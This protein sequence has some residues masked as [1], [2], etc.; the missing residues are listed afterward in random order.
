[1]SNPHDYTVG[2]ICA[3]LTEYVAAQAFLDEKHEGPESVSTNDN[4]DYTLGRIGKHNV[5]IAVLPHGE[6][7]ISSAA[8]VARDMLHSFPNVKIGLMVGIGGGAPSPKHDIR[9]GDIV[10]SA[11]GNGKGGV[12]QFDYGKV[13]QNE[14]FQETGFLNQPPTILRAAVHGLM[15]QYESEGHQLEGSINSILEKKP[16]LRKKYKRPEPSTDRLYLPEVLHQP[17]DESNCAKVCGNG[18]STLK[19][20]AERTE[21]KD[22]P[23]IHYGLI[24]SSNRVVKDAL[25]RDVLAEKGA[26]CF[27]MEAAGLMNHFPCLVIRGICDYSDTHKNKEWQGYTAMVAAAYAKDL[28]YRLSPNKVKNEKTISQ[29][30]LVQ[31][32][33]TYNT[34]HNHYGNSDHDDVKKLFEALHSPDP[35]EVKVWIEEENND[36]LLRQSYVWILETPEF[37]AWRDRH[38]ENRLLWIRGDPGKGKTMLLCGIIN[39]LLPSSKFENPQSHISLA[40]FFCRAS[41]TGLDTSTA[42]LGGLIYLLVK[43]QP[44][45]LSHLRDA[46]KDDT[47]YWK[48]RREMESL[49]RKIIANPAIKEIYLIVDA[50]DECRENLEFLLKIIASSTPRIKWLV[51][52]RDRYEIEENLEACSSKLGLRLEHHEESVSEAVKYFIDYRTLQLVKRKK[53]KQD[54]AQEIHC[55]LTQHAHGTFL[56]VALVCRRLERCLP[57]EIKEELFKLPEGLNE[58]YARMIEEIGKSHS[59]KLYI[60]LLA[61]ASTVFRPLTSSELIAMEQLD[62]DEETLPIAIKECGSFLSLEGRTVFF[63]HQSAKEFLLNESSDLLF[64][65]GLMHY[66]YALFRKSINLLGALH[67]DMYHLIHP[68]VSLDAAVRN[69][70]RPDPLGGF[71]YA[72]VFWVDHIREVC[73]LATKGGIRE[74]MLFVETIHEF[75]MDKFLFWLEA[76]SLCKNLPVAGRALLFLKDHP[77]TYASGLLFS[78]NKSLIR[79][80]FERCTPNFIERSPRVDDAW[81]PILSIFETTPETHI[82]TLSFS[83]TSQL[84]AMTTS[85]SQLLIWKVSDGSMHKRSKYVDAMLL[86][87]SPDLQYLAVITTRYSSDA[88]EFVQHAIEVRE[89]DSNN[90]LWT[91]P[92][93][94]RKVFAMEISPDSMWLAVCYENEIHLYPCGGVFDRQTGIQYQCPDLNDASCDEGFESINDAKFVTNTHSVLICGSEMGIYLWEAVNGELEQRLLHVDYANCL[95]CSHYEAWVTIASHR[96]LSLLCG[97]QGTLLQSLE[98]PTEDS[99]EAIKVAYDD[100]KIAVCSSTTVWLLDVH[101]IPADRPSSERQRERFPYILNDGISIAYHDLDTTIEIENPMAGVATTLDIRNHVRG[102]VRFMAFSPEGQLFCYSDRSSIHVWDLGK[103]SWRYSFEVP[104]KI[105]HIAISSHVRGDGQWVAVCTSFKVLVWNITTGEFQRSIEFPDRWERRAARAYFVGTKLGVAWCLSARKSIGRT[106][107][108]AFV[109]FDI[110]TGHQLAQLELPCSWIVFEAAGGTLSVSTNG[111]WTV[112]Y[113]FRS[114]QLLLSD[115]DTGMYCAVIDIDTQWFS[116]VD[117]S[118]LWTCKGVFDLDRVLENLTVDPGTIKRQIVTMDNQVP[119]ELPVIVPNFDKYGCSTQCDW[120]TFHGKPLIWLPQQY[121]L[122]THTF[123]EQMAIGHRHITI[124][125]PRG[126]YSIV[127]TSDAGDRLQKAMHN[128]TMHDGTSV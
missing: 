94:S 89:L 19:L 103:R 4:N 118:V 126:I 41:E 50:L 11:S 2:W 114:R 87:P 84:L 67:Q 90:T 81:S 110:K 59:K 40:Y 57:W 72:V 47:S 100:S 78:P 115:V 22:N 3:I 113:V 121:R 14:D 13:K 49:F 93:S 12:F 98:L 101:S 119:Q 112:S 96:E 9:L 64:P 63:I 7:G 92:L 43:Q 102:V 109:L 74:E 34:T 45:L 16:R 52:S 66:H 55:Y 116:F 124:E 111:K 86:T 5:A 38:H 82:R 125:Y 53:I 30:L 32:G 58:F 33:H 21:D 91:R 36:C 104:A 29:V 17:N 51:S 46:Q 128:L 75:L 106:R 42:V 69:R 107:D 77:T 44:C 8:S 48:S 20:R 123:R 88:K 39:E 62:I 15:A 23:S 83:S 1:M 56:W 85:D 28:L 27:E 31:V 65:S 24:A 37:L 122:K 80:M 10:V 54:L 18:P 79:N 26:L 71:I 61:L 99:L 35:R 6:Y 73:Q 120:I 60:R 117:D 76:L 108:E 25:V 97:N 127:S 70:P 95:A 105:K 68:G